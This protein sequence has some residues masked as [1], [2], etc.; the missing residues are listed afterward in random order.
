MRDFD[1]SIKS[2]DLNNY[3]R[4]EALHIAFD[5]HLNVVVGNNGVGKT[6]LL[7]GCAVAVS[8]LLTKMEDSQS[9][10]IR[11]ADARYI[12]VQK[13]S[14]IIRQGQYPVSVEAAGSLNGHPYCWSCELS[15]EKSKMTRKGAQS[16]IAAGFDLQ[17]GGFCRR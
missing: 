6:T 9:Y 13:G 14:A 3:R 1:F 2:L 8:S 16:I 7:E 4:F 15:S 5:E 17:R 11:K 12:T 10:G